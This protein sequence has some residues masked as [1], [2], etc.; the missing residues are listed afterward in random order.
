DRMGHGDLFF[1]CRITK[2]IQSS[3]HAPWAL[4]RG[5]EQA[6]RATSFMRV[7][8]WGCPGPNFRA[9]LPFYVLRSAYAAFEKEIPM[10]IQFAIGFFKNAKVLRKKL[11]ETPHFSVCRES[12]KGEAGYIALAL[13]MYGEGKI[14]EHPK[15]AGELSGFIRQNR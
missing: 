1:K 10:A 14:T 15:E 8:F 4:N 12:G 3:W 6:E 13:D 11:F 9:E 2:I 7:P 5:G